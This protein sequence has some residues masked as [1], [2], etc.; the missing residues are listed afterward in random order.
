MFL[1][2]SQRSCCSDTGWKTVP[3]TSSR[4]SKRSITD[5][6]ESSCPIVPHIQLRNHW[7]S[8]ETAIALDSR[9][10]L[11][12]ISV[13]IFSFFI[14]LFCLV[15]CG[16]LSWLYDSFWA[17]VNILHCLSFKESN[18]P[19]AKSPVVDEERMRP[20]HWSWLVLCDPFSA[21]TLVVGRQERYLASKAIRT[22]H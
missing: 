4:H 10:F 20:G 18:A 7:Y 5:G 12:S 16:R 17:H 6:S 11:L 14:S 8:S 22:N 3:C 2:G 9:P 21:S 1:E 13:F 15:P 19:S